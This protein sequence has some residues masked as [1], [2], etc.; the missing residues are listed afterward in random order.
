M[1]SVVDSTAASLDSTVLS[2]LSM[3]LASSPLEA[4]REI[5]VI[6][7]IEAELEDEEVVKRSVSILSRVPSACVEDYADLV[8]SVW[9]AHLP[10]TLPPGFVC[11]RDAYFYTD[12]SEAYRRDVMLRTRLINEKNVGTTKGVWREE[13]MSKNEFRTV[14]DY[15]VIGYFRSLYTR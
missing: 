1:D 8:L 3:T 12:G 5:L 10:H 9:L 6:S 2:R 7:G 14:Y 4:V 13:E 11:A 15:I